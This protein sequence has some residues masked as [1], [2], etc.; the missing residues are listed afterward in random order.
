MNYE[1]SVIKFILRTLG[2]HNTIIYILRYKH[3]RVFYNGQYKTVLENTY[4]LCEYRIK[5]MREKAA[6]AEYKLFLCAPTI[7]RTR[8]KKVSTERV[9]TYAYNVT[10]NGISRL[11]LA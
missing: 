9:D 4:I 11:H 1:V 10:Y 3:V 6:N 8:G 2:Q 7:Y 5:E